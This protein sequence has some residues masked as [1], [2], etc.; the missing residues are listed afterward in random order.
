MRLPTPLP[1]L[2][3]VAGLALSLALVPAGPASAAPTVTA[4]TV[5]SAKPSTLTPEGGRTLQLQVTA[6][7]DFCGMEVYRF[8]DLDPFAGTILG[9]SSTTSYVDNSLTPEFLGAQV[10]YAVR[11]ALCDG[12]YGPGVSAPTV[13]LD[14]L[15]DQRVI[16]Q[17]WL[18][19]ADASAFTGSYSRS[20]GAVGASAFLTSRTTD[21]ERA[22]YAPTGPDGGIAT[23]YVDGVKQGTAN[24]YSATKKARKLVWSAPSNPAKTGPYD[25]RLVITKAGGKGGTA[26]FFDALG[27]MSPTS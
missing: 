17:G 13:T 5:R 7:A 25:L 15:D 9:Y 10:R 14:A 6:S 22:I 21:S 19:V 23:V 2:G 16:R 4:V 8:S 27:T 3:A 1:A 24:F 26:M 20:G 11:P 18:R 12:E